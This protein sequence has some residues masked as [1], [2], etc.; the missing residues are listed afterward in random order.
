LL[1]PTNY[2][3]PNIKAEVHLEFVYKGKDAKRLKIISTKI[4]AGNICVKELV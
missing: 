1:V 2:R 4:E 3:I